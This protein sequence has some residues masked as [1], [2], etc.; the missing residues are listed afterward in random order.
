MI[1]RPPRSTLFPYTTLFRSSLALQL[2]FQLQIICDSAV[3][4][5]YDLPGAFAMRVRF[6]FGGAAVVG[7]ARVADSVGALDGR[8]AQ[9][10]FEVAQFSGGAANF[11]FAVLRDDGDSRRVVSAVFQLAQPFNDDGH[12]FFRSDITDNS[13]HTRFSY[14]KLRKRNTE[15]LS[16]VTRR[17]KNSGQQPNSSMREARRVQSTI[18]KRYSSITGL[19]STSLEMRSSC[20]CA[21]SRLQPSRF[22]T[23][24]FPWRTT[25]TC[26]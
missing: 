19:V 6:F 3:V 26:S 17:S 10:L 14:G 7:P 23:K 21:S 4:H 13:A 15:F 11:E 9:P 25:R 22:R 18:S 12:D 24:N 1:R 20:D 8:V 5:D 2:L 16:G